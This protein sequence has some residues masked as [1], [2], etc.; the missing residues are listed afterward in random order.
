MPV[1]LARKHLHNPQ[2]ADDR[3]HRGDARH[4]LSHPARR[5]FDGPW[6]LC[7]GRHL[8]RGGLQSS[9]LSVPA[10][11]ICCYPAGLSPLSFPLQL[12]GYIARNFK[13]Q[14]S[15]LGAALDPFADKFM[16]SVVTI[17]MT[18]AHLIPSKLGHTRL[19]SPSPPPPPPVDRLS[20]ALASLRPWPH[21]KSPVG[22]TDPDPRR[23]PARRLVLH[24]L[25]LP[26]ETQHRKGCWGKGLSASFLRATS[27]D[28]NSLPC[29]P[30]NAGHCCKVL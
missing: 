21:T 1:P 23:R 30:Q 13:G 15:F 8:R 26:E 28:P 6:P 27:L 17:A 11:V 25:H 22:G 9:A 10:L 16:V 18:V 20:L 7:R 19:W 2:P 29:F 24:P 5:V 3:A 4:R 12:D 14:A